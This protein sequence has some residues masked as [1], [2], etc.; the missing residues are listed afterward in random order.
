MVG[1]AT[2]SSSSSFSTVGDSTTTTVATKQLFADR[3]ALK[4]EL[5]PSLHIASKEV[6]WRTSRANEKGRTSLNAGA[7]A[8]TELPSAASGTEEPSSQKA[9][10]GRVKKI[11]PKTKSASEKQKLAED[12][13]ASPYSTTNNLELRKY[14]T[15]ALLTPEEEFKLGRQVQV[16]VQCEQVHE[17][18]ALQEMRLPTV[19]EWASACGYSDKEAGFSVSDLVERQLRPLGSENMFEETNPHMFVGNG[20]AHTIGVGRGRGR[21]KKPPPTNLKDVYELNRETLKKVS[22][23]PVNRGTPSDFIEMVWKA[24]MLSN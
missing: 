1:K 15:T 21:A 9:S 18:L 16:M 13:S 14:Y 8:A 3:D 11:L 5:S 20:L 23:T 2:G 12:F 22:K 6:E 19:E 10:R 17:G 24:E 4:E 7:E